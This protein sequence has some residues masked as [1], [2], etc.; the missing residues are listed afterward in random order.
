MEDSLR[1][2]SVCV[3]VRACVCLSARIKHPDYHHPVRY[4]AYGLLEFHAVSSGSL[5]LFPFRLVLV[6]YNLFW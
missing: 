4:Q 1:I 3:C 6:S 5:N 2:C